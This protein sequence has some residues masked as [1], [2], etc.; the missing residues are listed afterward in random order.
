ME[1]VFNLLPIRSILFDRGRKTVCRSK[2]DL[3]LRINHL[4]RHKLDTLGQLL[5]ANKCGD[6]SCCGNTL[7]AFSTKVPCENM[8]L[9]KS[10]NLDVIMERIG[11]SACLLPKSATLLAHGRASETE[12]IWVD[13]EGLSNLSRLKIQSTPYG[14]IGDIVRLFELICALHTAIMV[15]LHGL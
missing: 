2:S 10:K 4:G 3:L 8:G 6:I 12:R 1:G 7:R 14:N 9:A 5:V 11:Q 15:F 13:D